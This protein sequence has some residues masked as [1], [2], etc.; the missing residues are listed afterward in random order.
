MAKTKIR[1]SLFIGLGGTGMRTLLY[2]K[3]LFVDTY[4]EV[5]PMIGFLG[6]DT[7]ANEFTSELDAKRSGSI[8]TMKESD[9]YTMLYVKGQGIEQPKVRLKP[10]E[11]LWITLEHPRDIYNVRK[12]SFKW[13]P[14]SNID[15]LKTLVFGAGQVRTNG[16]FA[17]VAHSS[18][19]E[20]KV[21]SALSEVANINA[22]DDDKYELIAN[23]TDVYL[24]FSLGGG[25]GCGT[26]IDMA[27]LIR[28]CDKD[29][30]LAAYAL[31]P[32]VFR[33]EFKNAME[34]VL[35]NGYG[36]VEDLDWLM[37]RNWADDPI[38]IPIQDGR[39]WKTQDSPFDVCM[40]IDNTNKNK[41][42]Y[43]SNKQLEEMIA[44]SLVTSVGELSKANVSVLD[45]IAINIGGGEYNVEHKK[46]WVSGMGVCEAIVNTEELRRIYAHNVTINIAGQ[47]LQQPD[48]VDTM[49]LQW[50]DS[51]SVKIREH[52]ADDVIDFLLDKQFTHM[53]ELDKD[54]YSSAIDNAN[55][56]IQSQTPSDK[57]LNSKLQALTSRIAEEL[58]KFIISILNRSEGAGVGAA[59]Q[60]LQTLK[61]QVALYLD[62]MQDEKAKMQLDEPQYQAQLTNKAKELQEVSKSA[63][64]FFKS[65]TL[66]EIAETIG[67]I[68]TKIARLKRDIARHDKAITFFTDLLSRINDYR[69]K[70]Q[71]IRE[72]LSDI[73]NSS[74]KS[75]AKIRTQSSLQT[76]TFQYNLTRLVLEQAELRG[77][78]IMM[79]DFLD[80]LKGNKVWDFISMDKSTIWQYIVQ[81][82]Y[83]LPRARELGYMEV[84]NIIDSMSEEDFTEL[85]RKMVAKASPLLPVDYHGRRS[86]N[87]A[88]NYYIGV[89]DFANNRLFKDNYFK[90]NISDAA[91]VL[92]SNIGMT[93]RVII[94]SQMN[95]IPP[96]AIGSIDECRIEYENPQQTI[97][98]HFDEQIYQEMK[99]KCYSLMPG[100]NSD[101]ALD[102]WVRG[103]I[104]GLVKNDKGMYKYYDK[105]N[106]K[107]LLH[108]WV[109]LT[110]DRDEAFNMFK[111]QISGI[112]GQFEK[113]FAQMESEHGTPWIKEKLEDACKDDNYY[114]KYSGIDI[115]MSELAGDK[116]L[117][118]IANQIESEMKYL[119]SLHL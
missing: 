109:N 20:S 47:L 62:E 19:V 105:K 35:P 39:T 66:K 58:R 63:F 64:A 71:I 18:E 68:A 15:A 69:G 98:F 14:N 73:I 70:I 107:A 23:K 110:E 72:R 52:D 112:V 86:D 36:A 1:R 108:Y 91:D 103:F 93:D 57:D 28:R 67:N 41:D 45:N 83:N 102:L 30:K 26:F 65:D 95:P 3:K 46:A 114:N 80:Y 106:G 78:K 21:R 51:P 111:E 81:Y 92:F 2:L 7:D 34:R 99:R 22:V 10:S 31:L 97:S 11:Q 96:F 56:Y 42:V 29:C 24:I 89:K 54:D 5:P 9:G 84:N 8:G 40:F 113:Q 115:S 116:H 76:E 94:F 17:L 101:N 59:E 118:K 4:G 25:T 49:V 13:L 37:C 48:G 104:F 16:R 79:A 82:G 27:Y 33:T 85:V 119:S 90:N 117:E 50:I 74:I 60:A 6:V 55:A 38:E 100:N 87:P 75:K 32:K 43:T 44:L 61:S 12:Q 77:E 88:V 53:P